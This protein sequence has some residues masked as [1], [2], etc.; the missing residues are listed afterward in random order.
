[1]HSF[2]L[3]VGARFFKE[4]FD[5][6]SNG[7]PVS[8]AGMLIVYLL[9]SI[10]TWTIPWTMLVAL[11]L[12]FGRL[13]ADSEITAMRAC[14]VSIMQIISPILIITLMLTGLCFY[15]QL[16]VA[17]D[18]LGRART[19]GQQVATSHPLA[20]MTPGQEITF[21]EIRLLIDD[22]VGTDEIKGVQIYRMD[23]KSK[24]VLQDITASRGRVL[25]NQ[26]REE[27]TITLYNCAIIS[28]DYVGKNRQQTRTFSKEFTF[29]VN[30]GKEFNNRDVA[31]R[32][33]FMRVEEIFGTM[34][35]NSKRQL[36]NTEWEVE[37]TSAL[38]LRCRRS[39]SSCSGCRW[40]FVLRAGKL[41][42]ACFFR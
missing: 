9:P 20:F 13:S 37:L 39:R 27:L 24:N 40:Q 17:P 16:G 6:V 25:V 10:M 35:L 32:G 26:A 15:L 4:F 29:S 12:V 11:M 8:E 42:L 34:R 3:Y 31:K 22:R 23:D 30:Y 28:F 19:L 7:L 41:R 33:K 2:F 5:K 36:D 14:G 18:Y 1:M 21:N 38:R